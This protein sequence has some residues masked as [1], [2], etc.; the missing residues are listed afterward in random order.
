MNEPTTLP[1]VLPPPAPAP[2]VPCAPQAPYPPLSP[3]FAALVAEWDA[4]DDAVAGRTP[5]GDEPFPGPG[6]DDESAE[7]AEEIESLF[8]HDD[9][10][11][12]DEDDAVLAVASLLAEAEELLAAG[13]PAWGPL[14]RADVKLGALRREYG[15]EEW[16]TVTWTRE[17]QEIEAL[18]AEER[19][20]RNLARQQRDAAERVAKRTS[21]Q[22]A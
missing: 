12:N 19:R 1:S 15:C 18:W 9:D 11:R 20:L 8:D 3:A 13:S 5:Q 14:D 21:E 22:A 2:T 16:P 7:D 17:A 10:L 4:I 6:P